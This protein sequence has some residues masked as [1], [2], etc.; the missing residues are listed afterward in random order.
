MLIH[1]RVS[2]VGRRALSYTYRNGAVGLCRSFLGAWR[3][4]HVHGGRSLN[5]ATNTS[6]PH[7]ITYFRNCY[8][9]NIMSYLCLCKSDGSCCKQECGMTPEALSE[10]PCLHINNPE[11]DNLPAAIDRATSIMQNIPVFPTLAD[12]LPEFPNN[13]TADGLGLRDA[14]SD[15][16][17]PEPT[18]YQYPPESTLKI[19]GAIT[20]PADD[21]GESRPI[22]PHPDPQPRPSP[23]PSPE[24][25]ENNI[26]QPPSTAPGAIT[27]AQTSVEGRNMIAIETEITGE[28][29]AN[30]QVPAEKDLLPY[31]CCKC[32][33]TFFSQRGLNS[34]MK[35]HD[36][37]GI[38]KCDE[39]DKEFSSRISVQVHKG[40]HNK[41]TCQYCGKMV[42]KN[43]LSRHER[44]CYLNPHSD[45]ST[46]REN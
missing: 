5:S 15:P 18:P 35:A 21:D 17:L 25:E 31:K 37:K 36:A 38:F 9:L 34:H 26:S 28:Q 19:P 12:G 33:D 27:G 8:S 39:C 45:V 20:I 3:G 14:T 2:G 24:P 40:I 10:R 41:V 23:P 29:T 43:H 13:V 4:E 30:A 44:A 46:S 32:S 22:S 6:S 16:R 11:P 7:S 1:S 42:V